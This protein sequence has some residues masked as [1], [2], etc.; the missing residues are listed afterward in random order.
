MHVDTTLARVLLHEAHL[1][2]VSGPVRALA[3]ILG[4][5]SLIDTTN[6]PPKP[7]A[8]TRL[9]FPDQYSAT[10]LLQ[11]MAH[12]VAT[13]S[14]GSD[15]VQWLLDNA[16]ALGW[17][18]L[19]HLPFQTGMTAISFSAWDQLQDAI[20]LF[21]RYPPVVNPNDPPF[22]QQVAQGTHGPL[23]SG[24]QGILAIVAI[25][26]IVGSIQMLRQKTWG[27]A[28]TAS[29]LALCAPISVR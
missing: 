29:I 22:V 6:I 12:F 11:Q 13:T 17:L 15:D 1:K 7:P 28:L 26:T 10:L 27:L 8:I 19:D 20:G 4:D 9:A 23:A 21:Q 18:Q 3:D 5:D 24:M 14:L 2:T 16:A 25:I